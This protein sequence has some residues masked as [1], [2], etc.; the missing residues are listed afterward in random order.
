MTDIQIKITLTQKQ[1]D[2]LEKQARV[3]Q[4]PSIEALIRSSASALIEVENFPE[5]DFR[6][7]LTVWPNESA[8]AGP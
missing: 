5:D 8:P 3:K 2:A 7:T 6:N 1:F 4:F